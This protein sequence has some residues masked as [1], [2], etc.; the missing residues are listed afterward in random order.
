MAPQA[1]QE[2]EKLQEQ[3]LCGLEVCAGMRLSDEWVRWTRV[4]SVA[5]VQVVQVEPW[6]SQ[7]GA[8][9]QVRHQRWQQ[10]MVPGSGPQALEPWQALTGLRLMAGHHHHHRS[11]RSHQLRGWC[12]DDQAQTERHQLESDGQSGLCLQVATECRGHHREHCAM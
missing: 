3:L 6:G 10:A 8:S 4:L 2:R 5:V 1:D 9:E 11:W 12:E 7:P